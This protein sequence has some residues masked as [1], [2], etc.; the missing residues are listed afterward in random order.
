MTIS[1]ISVNTLIQSTADP[2]FRGQA[3]S[4]FMLAIRGGMALG[5]LATG[6]L[7]GLLGVRLAL[8]ID[9]GLA[10]LAH[11]VIGRFWLRAPLPAPRADGPPATA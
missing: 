4:M 5:S 9:G 1:N 2:A 8:T 7:V 6:L 3:V 11:F 10:V